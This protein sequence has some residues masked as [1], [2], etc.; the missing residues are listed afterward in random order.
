MPRLRRTQERGRGPNIGQLSEMLGF[1][2]AKALPKM[3]SD[4]WSPNFPHG[5]LADATD[6]QIVKVADDFL[7]QKG[8]DLW[9]IRGRGPVYPDDKDKDI[10]PKIFEI[11]K[12]QRRN[13]LDVRVKRDRR[14]PVHSEEPLGDN[15]DN[16][17]LMNGRCDRSS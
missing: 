15:D 10:K 17:K 1:T 16:G 8:S 9:S 12:R 2:D 11:L 5:Q 6:E 3:L 4:F 13:Q 14:Q 7:E